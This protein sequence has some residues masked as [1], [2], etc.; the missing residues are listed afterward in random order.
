MVKKAVYDK[1][2]EKVNKSDTSGFVLK[3][4]YDA[5]KSEIDKKSPDTSE[6]IKKTNCDNEITEIENLILNN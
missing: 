6:L 2:V 3:T 1:L 4:K 5:G